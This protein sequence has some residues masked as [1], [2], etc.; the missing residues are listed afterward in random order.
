MRHRACAHFTAGGKEKRTIWFLPNILFPKETIR[1]G[2][3]ELAQQANNIQENN[4]PELCLKAAADAT[5]ATFP[6]GPAI[7]AAT[8]AV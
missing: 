6:R 2:K 3:P 4:N 8:A 1:G 5:A 7:K